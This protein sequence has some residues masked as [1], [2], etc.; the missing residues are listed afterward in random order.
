M[1]LNAF[2]EERGLHPHPGGGRV[3]RDHERGTPWQECVLVLEG[4]DHLSLPVLSRSR[5]H[6]E[7]LGE[8]ARCVSH[9]P[10]LPEQWGQH[11]LIDPH[12]PLPIHLDPL[13]VLRAVM[14]SRLEPHRPYPTHHVFKGKRLEF[15]PDLPTPSLQGLEGLPFAPP[16]CLRCRSSKEAGH[17]RHQKHHQHRAVHAG[18]ET[19]QERQM[20]T[21]P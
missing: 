10:P 14:Q 15:I 5:Q 17:R 13:L 1:V 21:Q 3:A 19:G 4:S 8:P 16:P 9:T 12:R 7:F 2:G 18:A 6:A 11:D 20:H